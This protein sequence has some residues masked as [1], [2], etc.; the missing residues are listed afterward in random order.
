MGFGSFILLL[1]AIT[2][3]LAT[4]LVENDDINLAVDPKQRVDCGP[5]P[6]ITQQICKKRGCIWAPTSA[7]VNSL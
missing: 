4:S 6:S 1:L 2:F 3:A 5:E 7:P